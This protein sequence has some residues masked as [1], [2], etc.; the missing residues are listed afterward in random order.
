MIAQYGHG[1]LGLDVRVQ[2]QGDREIANGLQRTVWHNDFAF[3]NLKALLG[4]RLSDIAV[5]D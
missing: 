2:R 4:Q 3:F 1:D 5:G